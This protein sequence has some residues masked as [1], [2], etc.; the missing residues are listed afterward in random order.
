[1]TWQEKYR[2]SE[3][4]KHP[5]V[6][7]VGQGDYGGV[8]LDSA[9]QVHDKLSTLAIWV[10]EQLSGCPRSILSQREYSE[11]LQ[12]AAEQFGLSSTCALSAIE[13]AWDKQF[14][15]LRF[16][17]ALDFET[18]PHLCR[19]KGDC[20]RLNATARGVALRIEKALAKAERKAE[21][22][23]GASAFE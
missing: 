12:R 20:A 11:G 17:K 13:E 10:P 18:Y 16:T 3:L 5:K 1:M 8:N 2:Y 14:N 7:S 22:C 4:A 23:F 21:I 6:P 9:V 19:H 15:A